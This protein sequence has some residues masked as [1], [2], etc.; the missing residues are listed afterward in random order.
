MLE[1]NLPSDKEL[2]SSEFNELLQ[3][4]IKIN[5]ES[6]RIWTILCKKA[7]ENPRKIDRKAFDL[8]EWM[9]TIN[10]EA[11]IDLRASGAQQEASE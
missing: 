7:V 2:K 4:A 8:A 10:P 11:K 1:L 9:Q 6:S 5:Q 3:F